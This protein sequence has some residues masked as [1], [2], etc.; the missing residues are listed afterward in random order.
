MHRAFA[1]TVVVGRIF[2]ESYHTPRLQARKSALVRALL[3]QTRETALQPITHRPYSNMPAHT[4]KNPEISAEWAQN[5]ADGNTNVPRRTCCT[6]S[7][8]IP[9][10]I[11]LLAMVIYRIPVPNA[12]CEMRAVQNTLL[13]CTVFQRVL[14]ACAVARCACWHGTTC[15]KSVQTNMLWGFIKK[16]AKSLG[17]CASKNTICGGVSYHRPG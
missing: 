12:G 8:Q 11:Q 10:Y 1:L 13:R 2:A 14:C 16:S 4:R 15:V 7:L 3:Y 5:W 9:T 6:P 17:N